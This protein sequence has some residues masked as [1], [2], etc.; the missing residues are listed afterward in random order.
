MNYLCKMSFRLS[1]ILISFLLLQARIMNAE[2]DSLTKIN[3]KNRKITLGVSGAVFSAGSI[4]YL[5]HAWFE[6]YNTGKFHFFNDN[7]E[8]NQMDKCGH[9][10]T[11]YQTGRLMMDAFDW[12]GYN[13]NT[14]LIVAG[15][16]GLYYMTAIEVMDGFSEGWG[17]SAGDIAANALGAGLAVSQEAAWNEQRILLKFSYSQ[18]G[19]A[20]YDPSLLGENIYT[21]VLK[22]YNG[23]TYWLSVNPSSF[24][25]KQNKFTKWLNVAFGYSS[26]GMLGGFSNEFAIQDKDGNVYRYDRERRYYFSLDVDLTRIKTRSKFLKGLFSAFNV[27]KFPAPALQLSKKGARGYW[28][29]M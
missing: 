27:L 5:N 14:K 7:K 29:Y 3:Y 15:G 19:L 20:E 28:I 12:A 13:K 25:K 22:D 26:Y 24:M 6:P 4:V 23:Q 9:A 8:W 10:F 18:S 11:C 21:Q 2:N 1:I 17:F 16:I